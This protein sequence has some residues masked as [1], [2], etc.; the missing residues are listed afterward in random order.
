MLSCLHHVWDIC[1]HAV[2]TPR[3]PFSMSHLRGC[4]SLRAPGP[5]PCSHC[6][7]LRQPHCGHRHPV[8]TFQGVQ[9]TE[10]SCSLSPGTREICTGS[11]HAPSSVRWGVVS[12]GH[13]DKF[14]HHCTLIRL[15]VWGRHLGLGQ[16]GWVPLGVLGDQLLWLLQPQELHVP[17]LWLS[18]CSRPPRYFVALPP[19]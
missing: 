4:G 8:G 10:L 11:V 13:V 15:Q 19:C 17:R 6:P 18:N 3:C 7:R 16:S 5:P 9:N 14:P 12:Y 2:S 1:P